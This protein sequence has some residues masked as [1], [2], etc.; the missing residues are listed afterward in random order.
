MD[1][2]IHPVLAAGLFQNQIF[3]VTGGGTGIGREVALQAARLGAKGIALCGRRLDPL[4]QTALDLQNIGVSVYYDQCDIRDA[5]KVDLFVSNVLKRFLRVD[6]L[7]NNAGG[8]FMSMAENLSSKGFDAVIRNNLS[9]P[10]NLTRAVATQAFIPQKSGAIVYVTAQVRSGFP[11]MVHTGAARAGISNITKTLAI[12]WS[13]FGIRIN[14][15]APGVIIT[16]GTSQYPPS[17]MAQAK[18]RT[19]VNRLGTKEEVATLILYLSSQVASGFITG[20]T[21]YIDGGQSLNG[22]IVPLTSANL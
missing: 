19:P 15:V 10:W 17:F 5:D 13:K 8:Q 16:T 6:V 7:I 11:G 3:L 2:S 21:Y 12:E 20:Q 14:S 1:N 9:G 22:P 4:K 18:E